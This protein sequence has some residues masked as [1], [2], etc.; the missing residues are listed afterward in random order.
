M[1]DMENPTGRARFAM[2][3][4]GAGIVRDYPFFGV[5]PEMVET[6]YAQY[7]PPEGVNVTNP[8]L[9]NV[10]LQIA[11]E[12]GLPA[13]GA[14]LVFFA[15]TAHDLFRAFRASRHPVLAAAGIAA[16]AAMA[17]AGLFEYN[18]G[19]SEFLMLLLL[20]ITL[21]YAAARPAVDDR[22]A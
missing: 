13:L 15:L 3:Q 7:R 9:H 10:P 14:W 4:V 20:L 18:F 19:D 11:A 5:G 17:T 21:P 1:V 12:R 16:L 2:M 6:V 8:H 22:T